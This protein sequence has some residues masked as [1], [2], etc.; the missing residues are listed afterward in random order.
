VKFDET[1][2]PYLIK[3]C[4]FAHK[5]GLKITATRATSGHNPGSL[6]YVGRAID[7][8]VRGLTPVQIYKVINLAHLSGFRVL[9]ER[10]RPWHRVWT[11]PHL[12]IEDR[13]VS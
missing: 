1:S 13:E 12:H 5:Q 8:S 3:L 11:G 10:K 7:V 4:R 9:D 2:T 6:H